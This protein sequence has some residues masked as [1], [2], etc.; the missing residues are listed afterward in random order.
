[1]H[2]HRGVAAIVKNHVRA[3]AIWPHQDLLGAPPVLGQGFAL[4]G[5]YWNT[6]RVS[7]RALAT[8]HHRGGSVILGREDIA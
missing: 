2:E 3:L 6:L 4:P 7:H 1:M 8:N 5:E